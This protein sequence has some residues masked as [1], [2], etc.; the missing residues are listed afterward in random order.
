MESHK[1]KIN[2]QQ[3]QEAQPSNTLHA[4]TPAKSGEKKTSGTEGE[5]QVTR[6]REALGVG[7]DHRTADMIKKG[8]GTF[9]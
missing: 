8:R 7:K 4:K 6:N 5:A 9:P 2:V 3:N 1:P